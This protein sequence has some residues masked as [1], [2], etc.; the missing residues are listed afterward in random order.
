VQLKQAPIMAIK[1]TGEEVELAE[2]VTPPPTQELVADNTAP[3]Q[4]TAP[5]QEVADRVAPTQTA[6]ATLP[7][8]ASWLPLIALFGLLALGGVWVLGLVQKRLT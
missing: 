8:T 3:T 2:V 5:A 1:P 6:A 7:Q 4:T